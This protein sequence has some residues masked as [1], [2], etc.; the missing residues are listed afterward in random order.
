MQ[1]ADI[2]KNFIVQW[3]FTIKSLWHICYKIWL[4]SQEGWLVRELD[5]H[6]CYVFIGFLDLTMHKVTFLLLFLPG[7]ALVEIFLNFCPCPLVLSHYRWPHS[8]GTCTAAN[9]NKP[10]TK[11][12]SLGWSVWKRCLSILIDIHIDTYV[13]S[14]KYC[15]Y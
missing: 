15:Y 1:Q 9:Q 3:I 13:S 2:Q 4:L 5:R 6:P 8:C 14:Y 10:Q 11:E 7:T 12:C